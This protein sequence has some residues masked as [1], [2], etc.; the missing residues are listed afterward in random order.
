MGESICNKMLM[1][2][3][4]IDFTFSAL[5]KLR[6]FNGYMNDDPD[7]TNLSALFQFSTKVNL[8]FRRGVKAAQMA[9]AKRD[10]QLMKQTGEDSKSNFSVK[11]QP[12]RKTF[13]AAIN[14]IGNKKKTE[15]TEAGQQ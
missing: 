11:M 7:L 4:C 1:M 6:L 14:K 13:H 10:H 5:V 15:N 8:Y 3:I 12:L 2:L 9:G